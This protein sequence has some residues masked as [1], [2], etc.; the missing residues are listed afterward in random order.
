VARSSGQRLLTHDRRL[1]VRFVAGAD[2]A[3]RGSL[4]GP[5]VVAGPGLPAGR[6]SGDAVSLIDVAPTVMRLLEVTPFDTDGVDLRPAFS[7]GTLTPR[8]LK[9]QAEIGTAPSMTLYY[10]LAA[11]LVALDLL[12]LRTGHARCDPLHVEQDLPRLGH[13]HVD[14]ELVFDLHWDSSLSCSRS[15]GVSTSTALPVPSHGTSTTAWRCISWRAPTS[16]SS[17]SASAQRL[18]ARSTGL[19]RTPP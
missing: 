12:E 7:G 8:D 5:L 1:G 2:E 19:P 6:T 15:C 10:A 16:P 18:R 9:P 17:S 14:V 3:G 11:V 13:G 4:A